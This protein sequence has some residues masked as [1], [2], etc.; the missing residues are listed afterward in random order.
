MADDKLKQE[1]L[2]MVKLTSKY[3]F[4]EMDVV[5]GILR[6]ENERQILISPFGRRFKTR[7]FDIA[8][9]QKTDG[10]CVICG[11][12]ADNK[13][14]CQHCMETIGQSSYA[15]PDKENNTLE[16][17]KKD[18][19]PVISVLKGNKSRIK[20][21]IQIFVIVCLT[22]ILFIQLYIAFVWFTTFAPKPKEKVQNSINEIVAVSSKDE[23]Y[24]QLILD[25]PED[26][27]YTVAFARTD[28]EYVGRFLL[29]PGACCE[30][31][32]EGLTDEE[33]YDYFF[34]EDVYIFYIT[35]VKDG[36]G[37]IGLAE[38]NADGAIVTMGF[39]N[40]E[41]ETDLHYKF[42]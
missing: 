38:V 27:G 19:N 36:V 20:R 31:V 23:A 22:L 25:F 2:Y 24:E 10:R 32:E 42:R 7:I 16:T 41:H 29:E 40:N 15:N 37:K 8:S 1:L 30:E 35:C 11:Q 18:S 9:G 13:V 6:L 21:N 39:F 12:E 14:I 28:R 26:Q 34:S 3:N 17:E 4:S 33:R 5:E